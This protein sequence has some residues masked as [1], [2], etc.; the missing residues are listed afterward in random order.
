MT[1]SLRAKTTPTLMIP[2]EALVPEQGRTYVFVVKDGKAKRVEV[3]TGG[4]EPG[5][6]AVLDGLTAQDSLVVEGTQ[7]VRDGGDVVA[8]PRA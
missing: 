8:R 3:R 2:E 6:V 7:R 5:F 1:V 4:R